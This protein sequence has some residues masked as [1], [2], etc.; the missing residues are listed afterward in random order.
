M[1][2]IDDDDGELQFTYEF[3]EGNCTHSYAN[4]TAHKMGIKKEITDR[5]EE[6]S[7]V[8]KTGLSLASVPSLNR[9]EEQ[10]MAETAN[11]MELLMDDFLNWDMRGDPIGF[12]EKA[13]DVLHPNNNYAC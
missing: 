7:K 11:Q 2:V 9:E 5:A 4:Y 3:V 6:I 12:L 10:K 8:L 13:R 1:K